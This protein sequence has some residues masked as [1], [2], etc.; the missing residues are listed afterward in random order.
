MLFLQ[1][2]ASVLGEL[3]EEID[4][5]E[6]DLATVGAGAQTALVNAQTRLG[7]VQDEYV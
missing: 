6:R 1:A 4:R 3:R 7:A 2:A 5:L